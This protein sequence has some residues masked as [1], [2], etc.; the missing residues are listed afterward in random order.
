[1]P[2]G[3]TIGTI[4]ISIWNIF[5]NIFVWI[6][7]FCKKN[8]TLF[9]CLILLGS[10]IA[11]SALCALIIDMDKL[12]PGMETSPKV[13]QYKQIIM[14][15]L[16][17]LP[18]SLMMPF[19]GLI[20]IT[21]NKVFAAASAILGILTLLYCTLGVGIISIAWAQEPE[22]EPYKHWMNS[23]GAMIIIFFIMVLV[24]MVLTYKYIK[25]IVNG[26]LEGLKAAGTSAAHG[27][28]GGVGAGLQQSAG[29]L[30]K[31]APQTGASLTSSIGTATTKFQ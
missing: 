4:F 20:T 3:Q 6:F 28:I 10:F 27:S 1:M 15:A 9:L 22:F 7:N 30:G 17:L 16:I 8:Y 31:I 29:A 11:F 26:M 25:A 21:Q 14:S 13:K 18:A 24:N 23:I 19:L 12:D 2:I 5:R